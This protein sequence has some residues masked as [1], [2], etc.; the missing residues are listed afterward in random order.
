MLNFLELRKM[1]V[2]LRRTPPPRTSVNKVKR[3]GRG[4]YAP[5]LVP[6]QPKPRHIAQTVNARGSA[7]ATRCTLQ[8]LVAR[9]CRGDVALA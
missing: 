2:Q 3:K 8:P 5:A 7:Y 4:C 9:K 1:D 6:K